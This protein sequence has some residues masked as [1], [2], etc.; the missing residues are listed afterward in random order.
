MEN[1]IP[2]FEEDEIHLIANANVNRLLELII[3]DASGSRLPPP[4]AKHIIEN[5]PD[6][7]VN[8]EGK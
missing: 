1:Y 7:K 3:G 6:V 8:E 5:L 4:A 2:I